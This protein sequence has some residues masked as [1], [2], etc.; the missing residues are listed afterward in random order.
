MEETWLCGIVRGQDAQTNRLSGLDWIL[1]A[2]C[3]RLG[4]AR[5]DNDSTTL[6]AAKNERC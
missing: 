4:N 6:D 5:F 1:P 2:T 3:R